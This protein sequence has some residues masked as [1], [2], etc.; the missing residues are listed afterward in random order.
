MRALIWYALSLLG[1]GQGYLAPLLLFATALV[2]LTTNDTGAL[3]GS[4]AACATAQFVCL[5]WLTVALLNAEDAVQRTM[6]VVNAGS[7]RRVLLAGTAAA[8]LLGALL[9]AAGLIYPV[10]AGRHSVTGTAVLVGALAQLSCGAVGVAVGLLCCRQVIPR[11]GYAVLAA[12]IAV[13]TLTV[14][15]RIPPVG[16]LVVLLS[17]DADPATMLP[18][19]TAL[20]AAA[21]AVLAASFTA[22][23]AVTRHRS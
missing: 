2:V 22:V 18:P 6:T 4:Y 15:P 23:A 7:A 21:V 3:T 20:T 14:V 1:R 8:L 16:P 5:T 19:V 12:V 9:T 11:A 17:R 13:G 10:V